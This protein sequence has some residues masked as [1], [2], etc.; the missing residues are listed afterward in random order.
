MYFL[1]Q[2][3]PSLSAPFQYEIPRVVKEV[4]VLLTILEADVAQACISNLLTR[5]EAIRYNVMFR[6]S[7][8]LLCEETR[9]RPRLQGGS[10]YYK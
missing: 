2:R 3:N 8:A 6:A 10:D 1:I 5:E 9:L 4:N 7:M